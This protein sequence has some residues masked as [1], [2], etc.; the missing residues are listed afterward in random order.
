MVLHKLTPQEQ[1]QV[2]DI[3]HSERF[4]D[5]TPYEV[6]FTLLDEWYYYCSIRSMY[7][8]LAEHGESKARR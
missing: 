5:A 7:R 1:Q 8:I 4:Y 3:L 6:Y 2:L